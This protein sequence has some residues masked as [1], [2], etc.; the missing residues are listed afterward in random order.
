MFLI[1]VRIPSAEIA[2]LFAAIRER[3]LNN[4]FFHD[5][6]IRLSEQTSI[7][8]NEILVFPLLCEMTKWQLN[9]ELKFQINVPD[10]LFSV[11]MG[12]CFSACARK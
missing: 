8:L 3:Q 12:R 5:H 6:R 1:V 2:K 9:E 4:E 7:N 11:G 10:C